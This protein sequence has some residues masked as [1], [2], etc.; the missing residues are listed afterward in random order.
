M[1][2]QGDNGDGQMSL[3]SLKLTHSLIRA[4]LI[5]SQRTHRLAER[6]IELALRFHEASHELSKFYLCLSERFDLLTGL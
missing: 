4:R 3:L 2:T 5:D 6:L 1:A